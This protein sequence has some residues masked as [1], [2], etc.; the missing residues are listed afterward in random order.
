MAATWPDEVYRRIVGVFCEGLHGALT[1]WQKRMTNGWMDYWY[2]EPDRVA[3]VY[4]CH[5]DAIRFNRLDADPGEPGV[6]RG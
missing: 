4:G 5:M 6:I 3:M 1:N 2:N